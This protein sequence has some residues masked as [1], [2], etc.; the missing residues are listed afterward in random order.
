MRQLL[1]ILLPL[2]LFLNVVPQSQAQ[3][4]E[5]NIDYPTNYFDHPL[6]LPVTLAATFGEIRPN[7]FHS[8][9]DLR[10]GGKIGEPIYAPADGYVSRI[11]ISAW[12]G[13]K[14]LYITHPNGFRTVYMHCNDFVGEAATFARNYQYEHHTFTMD[15]NLPKDSIKVRRGQLIAHA[16]NTGGSGGPH[17][18]Y[19]IRYA[20]N[21]QPI[22][23]FYFG[24]KYNDNIAPTIRNIK[25]YPANQQ[26]RLDDQWQTV[27]L[28]GKNKKGYLRWI[29]TVRVQGRFYVG[30]YATDA[31]EGSTQKNGVEMIE[32]FVDDTLF[33][34]Y[35]NPT[36]L[37]EETRA[38]NAIIDYD[39]YQRSRE[40]YI[41]TR[42]L[43]GNK[44]S[45]SRAVNGM[46]YLQFGDGQLHKLRYVVSDY[47]GNH[48]SR[49]FY[50]RD[51]PGQQNVV[52]AD[53]SI[54]IPGDPI[55][56]YKTKFFERPGFSATIPIGTVYENDILSYH[57]RSSSGLAPLHSLTL[58]NYPLP[59]HQPFTVRLFCNKEKIQQQGLRLDQLVVVC[60]Q[61]SSRSALP[62]KRKGDW[63]EGTTKMFGTFTIEADTIAPKV[64]PVNFAQGKQLSSTLLKIK[65]SDNLSGIASYH[66]Y[67]NGTWVL[68]EHD[69]K[70]ASLSVS[71]A[72][73][74]H[75]GTNTIRIVVADAVGNTTDVEYHVLKK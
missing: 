71:A 50:V 13:G 5:G 61:G 24:T 28:R 40:Y 57:V 64:R 42:C 16:G 10:I 65:I 25:V 54:D 69:G 12:G 73:F 6:H 14:V 62:T 72:K 36:F 43:R 9:L 33:Y 46:G 8:G 29:D 21:D 27:T 52:P 11:N 2:L 67:I 15:V 30:V 7:H 51:I 70:T 1:L 59:P 63:L 56:Y 68:A 23:P 3:P 75:T 45:F 41:L 26:A 44:N 22:N 49:T 35:A 74:L 4:L 19:E 34:R 20:A 48:T 55:A 31:A 18:H 53:T 17:L 58:T 47:K 60:T 38:V 32:L 39:E 66:C 37:F